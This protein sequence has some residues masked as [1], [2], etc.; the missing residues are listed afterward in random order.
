MCFQFSP[1]GGVRPLLLALAILT[2]W[3]RLQLAVQELR[4]QPWMAA[5]LAVAYNWAVILRAIAL[6][7]PSSDCIGIFPLLFLFSL[8]FWLIIW[9][10]LSRTG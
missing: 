2:N 9:L 8:D 4:D 10:L 1:Q 7:V 6:R 5:T 3:E